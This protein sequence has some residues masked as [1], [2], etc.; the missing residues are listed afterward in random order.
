MAV[1]AYFSVIPFV[2]FANVAVGVVL[3]VVALVLGKRY[4]TRSAAAILGFMAITAAFW[5]VWISQTSVVQTES[6]T[7][8][9]VADGP[10]HP[11][12]GEFPVVLEFVDFPGNQLHIDSRDLT[13]Y[14]SVIA[15]AEVVIPVEFEV[16]RDFGSV[17]GFRETKIGELEAWDS[18]GGSYRIMNDARSPFR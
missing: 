7:M 4:Q 3:L 16:T 17:R 5:S 12:E 14:L 2:L 15:A 11:K 8:R 9:P 1:L 18:Q 10:G 6:F 13:A